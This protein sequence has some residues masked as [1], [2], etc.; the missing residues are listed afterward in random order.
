MKKFYLLILTSITFSAVG[1]FNADYKYVTMNPALGFGLG[2]SNYYGELNNVDGNSGAKASSLGLHLQYFHPISPS[3]Y[4]RASLNYNNLSHWGIDSGEVRNFHSTLLGMDVGGFYRLDND[5]VFSSQKTLTVF[6]GGG[7]GATY[8]NAKEDALDEN[9]LP[10]NYWTDGS[11]RST[12]QDDTTGVLTYRDYDYETDLSIEKK[13]APYVYLEVGFGLKIT[14]N[15]SANLSYKH[16]FMFSDELDGVVSSNN[17]DRF[18]YFNVTAIWS[19]GEPAYTADEIE[20][21]REA[22]VIDDSDLDGDGVRDLDDLCAKTPYGWEVD[23]TGCPL[24]ADGDKVPDAIDKEADTPSGSVV[25]EEGVALSDE[26]IEIIYLLQT[27][28]M[29]GHEKFE[30]WR[31][32]YPE[33][34]EGYYSKSSSNASESE[35]E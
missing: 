8:V 31:T 1:Q 18:D 27:D 10:Y 3:V 29:A 35:E 2:T 12:P 28:Q 6:V 34:F 16:S 25:N 11:I 13:V 26:E 7:F 20:R 4:G 19:F 14:Q 24:D 15:L 17:K 30:E 5:I 9:G 33:L 22:E 23:I 32:T 21:N